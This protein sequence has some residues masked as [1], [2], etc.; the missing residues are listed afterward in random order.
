[1]TRTLARA[2]AIALVLAFLVTQ[3]HAQVVQTYQG[4]GLQNL[5]PF[6]VGDHWEVRWSARGDYFS[7]YLNDANGDL[8]GV[9]ANQS[10][11]GRD[12][13][14]VPKGGRYAYEVNAMGAW[15]LE[16]VQLDPSTFARVTSAGHDE[17]GLGARAIRPFT[18]DGPWEVTWDARGDYFGLFLHDANGDLVDVSANQ[19][20]PGSSSSYHPRGGT[21]YFDV[22]ALG[23][24]TMRI[25]RVD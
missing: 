15:S 6:T 7:L 3:A 16:I 9:N 8:V 5:R 23:S 12:S 21:Y 20:G 11:P 25:E 17:S 22:N 1:M 10:G 2:L 18:V 14:Y 24:W 4:T 19:S 13:T